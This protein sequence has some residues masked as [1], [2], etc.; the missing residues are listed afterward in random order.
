MLIGH[1]IVLILW[2]DGLV[3]WWHV[4]LVVWQLVFAEILEK[5]CIARGVKVHVSVI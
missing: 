4:D 1:Y 2:V 5:V 3:L